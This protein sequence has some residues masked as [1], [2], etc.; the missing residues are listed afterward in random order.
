MLINIKD[1]MTISDEQINMDIK[2]IALGDP[3][4]PLK[5]RSM[6]AEFNFELKGMV[7]RQRARSS[8]RWNEIVYQSEKAARKCWNRMQR[9]CFCD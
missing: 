2:S 9:A 3:S 6:K 5:T 8:R 1:L 7:A 4:E